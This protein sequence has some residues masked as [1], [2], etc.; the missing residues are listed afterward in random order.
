MKSILQARSLLGSTLCLLLGTTVTP[1]LLAASRELPAF[2]FDLDSLSSSDVHLFQGATAAGINLGETWMRAEVNGGWFGVDYAPVDFD[3]FGRPVR[4]EESRIG[5]GLR[6]TRPI[7]ERW[8]L[9]ADASAYDGFQSYR[10]AWVSQWY[11]QFFEGLP[12]L[13]EA[14]PAGLSGGVGIRHETIP[15]RL[16]I[17]LDAGLAR[18]RIAPGYAEILDENES[19]LDVRPLRSQLATQSYRL[20]FEAAVTP[21][22]KTRTAIRVA[23]QV[24]RRPRWS[25]TGEANFAVGPD[26]VLRLDGGYTWEEL[27]GDVE[28]RFEGWWTGAGLEWEFQEGWHWVTRARAYR[29]NGEVE[30]S[31]SFSTSAPPL[32]SAELSMGLRW[33]KPGHTVFLSAGPYW[34]HYEP[35]TFNTAFFANLYRDRVFLAVQASYRWEF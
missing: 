24:E 16:W 32:D 23:D 8:T 21:W 17:Q 35:V 19:L 20:S 13:E 1:P 34:T 22:L 7:G 29:D 15:T 18:D 30:N 4:I 31:I 5:V 33:S 25:A 12:G 6:L 26:W 28:R 27:N 2:E 11:T 14:D 10:S 9:L 3:L